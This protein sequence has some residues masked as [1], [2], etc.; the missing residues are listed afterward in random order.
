MK[1]IPSFV[2]LGPAL[3]KLR[4]E[5]ELTLDGVAGNAGI[6]PSSLSRL[7]NGAFQPKLETLG[8]LL[9]ALGADP[10]DL[11]LAL[12]QAQGKTCSLELP[13]GLSGEER[14]ALLMT[15]YGFEAFVLCLAR[16]ALKQDPSAG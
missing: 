7:E 1:K 16:R 3:R 4:E 14:A 2:G 9:H 6:D 13:E 8:R 5:R 15:A 11:G 10:L 12:R